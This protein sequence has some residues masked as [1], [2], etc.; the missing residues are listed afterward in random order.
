MAARGKRV[1]AIGALVGALTLGL[2]AC[3]PPGRVLAVVGTSTT[4]NAMAELTDQFNASPSAST[5]VN[6]PSVLA[7]NQSVT[8]PADAQCGAVTY[9]AANPPPPD[10][11]QA[12]AAIL[13]DTTGCVDIA[14]SGPRRR[15]RRR[16]RLRV[17]A[18]SRHVD[19]VHRHSLPRWRPGPSRLRARR[20]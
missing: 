9:N 3:E 5:A 8:V 15:C 17:R 19:S 20:I 10:S 4:Q 16:G 12:F 2:S 11:D 7:P 13:A 6:V 1:V 14:R 18:R